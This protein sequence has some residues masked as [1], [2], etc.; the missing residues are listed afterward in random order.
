M[1][2]LVCPPALDNLHINKISQVLQ[3][4]SK[5]GVVYQIVKVA[6]EV[7]FCFLPEFSVH[8]DVWLYSALLVKLDYSGHHFQM[9]PLSDI[10]LQV[11]VVD[12]IVLLVFQG[13][14]QLLVFRRV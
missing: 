2:Y 4:F 13:Q 11:L 9:H 8:V 10:R 5:Y 7:A 3:C 12:H 1:A 14:Y 6:H